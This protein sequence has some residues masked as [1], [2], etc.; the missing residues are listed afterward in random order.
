MSFLELRDIRKSYYLGKEEFPV[1]KGIDLDFELGEFVS[2]LGE[3]G[4]GKS[5]LMNIIGGL[6][7]NF[8]G[9][10]T[11]NGQELDHK[12]EKQLDAYRRGT[13]GYIYQAYN[14]VS[15]LTVLE[16]V[17]VALDMTTLKRA[18]RLARATELL[19]Q[20]GLVDQMKKH[21]NQLSGGQ[22][23]RVAIARALAADPQVIIADEPTGALDSQ[24]TKEVLE[25]LNQIA[26][27][28]KLV[29]AVT[30]SQEVA[31]YGTRIVHLADGQID[32]D[33]RIKPAF[34]KQE[35]ETKI[36][37]KPLAAF[38]SYRTAFK[39][40]TYT[41]WRNFLIILGT[42][43]GL[44]AVMLFMGLGNGINGYIN[45]QVTD[46]ANPNY[47]TVMKNVDKDNKKAPTE[48]MGTTMQKMATDYKSVT[49]T[50]ADLK[51]LDN[52]KHVTAVQPGYQF[53]NADITYGKTKATIAT[54]QTWTGAFS[55]SS[56]KAGTKPG[57][58][59]ILVDKKNFAQVVSPKHWKNIIGKTVTIKYMAF[60]DN[61]TPVQVSAKA[62]VSGVV[63][64]G[65]S[66]ATLAASYGTMKSQLADAKANTAP[67]FASVKVSDT[68]YVKGVT[69]KI[70]HVK[71]GDK[72]AF[73]GI[74]VG[75]MLDTINTFTS[76]ATTVLAAIAGISLVV[77]ALMIIVTMYMSV[78]ERTKEIGI[79]RAL[80]ES[81]RDIRRLFT[82][83]S[84]FIGLLAAALAT[85]MAFG[86]GALLNGA[87]YKIAKYNMIAITWQNVV[88][89]IVVAI[90][91]AFLAALLPARR[92][93]RLN[94][95]DALS[96]D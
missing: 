78:S 53:S 21:P 43:I 22:K 63:D 5:T 85:A 2:I 76:L 59:E 93:S 4:G 66:G 73:I 39:H 15:H 18:E 60:A 96:A 51:R 1:L 19:E 55:D 94:P 30:H 70:N 72:Y 92:A 41:F 9:S 77:S 27:D 52:L 48:R 33:T 86:L 20:V 75:D 61:N 45:K 68:K 58:G 28:G 54:Y 40:L 32:G 8:E 44:F 25:L 62:K 88:F 42:A 90:V 56:I 38:A 3:S 13:I 81:K 82:S 71:D 24:N 29:I 35:T 89:A 83:E 23:Q 50:N 34:D 16:N 36:P 47:P 87:L 49:L 11:I 37:A 69:K 79:L 65:A 12:K 95:I 84:L 74:S 7:R 57:K 26:K 64:G 14:L 17:L 91:I 31:D 80:G 6:D 10:V 67:F 46:L